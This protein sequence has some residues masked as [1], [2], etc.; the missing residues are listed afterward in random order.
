MGFVHGKGEPLGDHFEKQV[1]FAFPHHQE[2]VLDLLQADLPL[3]AQGFEQ[4]G[5]VFVVEGN[6]FFEGFSV[7]EALDFVLHHL[8]ELLLKWKGQVL[9]FAGQLALAA[10]KKAKGLEISSLL[11]SPLLE[12]K[13]NAL[14]H[15][16]LLI[17]LFMS[18]EQC[19]VRVVEK[20]SGLAGLEIVGEAL[21][22]ESDEGGVE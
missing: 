5:Q 17:E 20:F 7:Q 6:C 2:Q 12:E 1:V 11:G 10:E 4:I 3:A 9:A 15:E 19:E 22:E 16:L 13:I 21:D 18:R 8:V 14:G